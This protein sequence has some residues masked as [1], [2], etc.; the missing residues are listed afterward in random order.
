MPSGKGIISDQTIQFTGAQT[1]KKCP[2]PMRRIHYHDA[3]TDKRYVFLTNSVKLAA[4]TIADFYKA[5][6]QV[7]L[8]FKWIKQHLKIKSF[9]GTSKNAVLTQ[10][11]V[12]LCVYQLLSLVK[13]QSKASRS[14]YEMLRIL[15]LN[16]FEKRDLIILLRGDPP[17]DRSDTQRQLALL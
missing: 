12:A 6:W 14:L 10:I 8:F 15:Q 2:L 4:R 11:W 13:F 5:R 17:D 16:L 3:V 7:E 9:V 1:A